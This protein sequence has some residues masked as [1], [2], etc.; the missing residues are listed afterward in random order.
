M[1][2]RLP[3]TLPCISHETRSRWLVQRM[4]ILKRNPN[5]ASAALEYARG[6]VKIF[7]GQYIAN[8]VMAN[9]AR[10]VICMAILALHFDQSDGNSGA[11]ITSIQHITT[12]LGLCSRSTTAATIDLLEKVGLVTRIQ[13]ESDH[14]QH[15]IRPSDKLVIGIKSM[16][17]VAVSSA[18]RLFPSRH[19]SDLLSGS[20]DF[21]ERYFASSLHSLLSVGRLDSELSGS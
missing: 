14:R 7:E 19:Y 1:D 3:E 16:V 11:I 20:D 5:F 15:L 2:D 8:K 12:V 18:D 9:L 10:R 17:A 21:T 4:E 6:A 13:G